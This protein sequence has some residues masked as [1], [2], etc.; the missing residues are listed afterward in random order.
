MLNSHE[1]EG[2][3]SKVCADGDAIPAGPKSIA[4]LTAEDARELR[5]RTIFD[6]G[7]K[8]QVSVIGKDIAGADYTADLASM[9]R[10][11]G[12]ERPQ[13]QRHRRKGPCAG[14]CDE[15]AQ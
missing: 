10:L 3:G 9:P 14:D 4:L 7:C 11:A 12:R 2:A 1:P 8:A 6:V 15:V 13:S 5:S